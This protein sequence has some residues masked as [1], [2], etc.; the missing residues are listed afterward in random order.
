MK[1]EY[2][3][4]W[5]LKYLPYLTCTYD[6]PAVCGYMCSSN[7]CIFQLIKLRTYTY[8]QT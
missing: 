3:L 6:L 4:I 7:K 8:K 1:Y 5:F 2:H